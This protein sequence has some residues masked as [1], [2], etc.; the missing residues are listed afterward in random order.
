MTNGWVKRRS[1]IALEGRVWGRPTNKAKLK[2]VEWS[3]DCRCGASK[4]R[5]QPR[6]KEAGSHL[7]LG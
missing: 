7:A 6:K 4:K 1:A 5:G 3:L 2:L